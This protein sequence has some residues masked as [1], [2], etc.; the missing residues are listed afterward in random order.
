M[1]R[2][3]RLSTSVALIVC[4]ASTPW[5][6][7]LLAAEE[8][9]E[10]VRFTFT[11]QFLAG[12]QPAGE[13]AAQAWRGTFN[14]VSDDSTA[15]AQRG[16]YRGRGSRGGSNGGAQAA[17]VLGALASITGGAVLVYANRPECRTNQRAGGCGYGTKV[18][19]GAVLTAGAVGFLA[20]VLT[21]R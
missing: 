16:R 8:K 5:S 13:A 3:H 17:V 19:G 18:V 10:H 11:D 21:W 7:T 4:V 2:T 9:Q 14:V 20:G 1:V 15:F 12:S 6:G